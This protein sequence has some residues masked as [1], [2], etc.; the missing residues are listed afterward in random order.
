MGQSQAVPPGSQADAGESHLAVTRSVRYN[1]EGPAGPP[2]GHGP[3]P[4]DLSH[5]SAGRAQCPLE[6][7]DPSDVQLLEAMRGRLPSGSIS[8]PS[9]TRG[10]NATYRPRPQLQNAATTTRV[11]ASELLRFI[12]I[13]LIIYYFII[14]NYDNK[15]SINLNIHLLFNIFIT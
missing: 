6:Q 4:C 3:C 14:I 2:G 13:L 15:Q 1:E 12:F 7:K 11:G 8:F 9:Y 10:G 5:P